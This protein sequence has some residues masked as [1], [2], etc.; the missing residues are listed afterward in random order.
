MRGQL[1]EGVVDIIDT[2]DGERM[3]FTASR[4]SVDLQAAVTIQREMSRTE[5]LALTAFAGN[6]LR[7][8]SA[9]APAEPHEFDAELHLRAGDSTEVLQFRLLEP[10]EHGAAHPQAGH[11][12]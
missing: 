7:F 12:H 9:A 3:Q 5:N 10:K 4:A 11:K 6:P 8:V 1:A 2:P